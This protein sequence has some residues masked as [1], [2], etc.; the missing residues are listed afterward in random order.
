MAVPSSGQLRL[1]ADI[2]NEVDGSATG[3]N[4]SLQALSR[5]AGKSTPDGMLEFYGYSASVAP[6][7]STSGATSITNSQFIANG[8]VSSDGGATVTERGFY[9][10]PYGGG[11]WAA[12]TKYIISGTTGAFSITR[13]GQSANTTLYITAYATNASGTTIAN[14]VSVATYPT[15]NY[16][17]AFISN[18]GAASTYVN[19][20]DPSTASATGDAS[21]YLI[22]PYLG[23][24]VLQSYSFSGINAGTSLQKL[25]RKFGIKTSDWGA[26]LCRTHMPISVSVP[27]PWFQN[28]FNNGD[29]IIFHQEWS[30]SVLTTAYG[31]AADGTSYSGYG[32]YGATIIRTGENNSYIQYQSGS[33]QLV[34]W[35]FHNNVDVYR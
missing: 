35:S 7:V 1:R 6:S 2:A 8:N 19:L 9:I 10:G 22:H 11:S 4:V 34:I 25:N 5:S 13:T 14:T 23:S 24:I 15:M 27:Y 30:K 32:G 21:D 33:G 18:S 31:W 3:S 28:Y 17:S 12:N 20:W 26:T 29:N 16:T